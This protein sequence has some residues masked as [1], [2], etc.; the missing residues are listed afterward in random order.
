MVT[1]TSSKNILFF[2]V[3]RVKKVN[4]IEAKGV[5]IASF[6]QGNIKVL[7]NDAYIKGKTKEECLKEVNS[8]GKFKLILNKK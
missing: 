2:E 4:E 8:K 5:V 3:V 6:K 7:I 1:R